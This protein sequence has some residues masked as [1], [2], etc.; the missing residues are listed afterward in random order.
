MPHLCEVYPRICL[1]TEGKA[2]K[3]PRVRVAGLQ[4]VSFAM[5]VRPPARNNSV[6]AGRISVKFGLQARR[7]GV[8]FLADARF[9]SFSKPPNRILGIP[10]L[11]FKGYREFL[12][13][14]YSYRRMSR[15]LISIE[16]EVTNEGSCTSTLTCPPVV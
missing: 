15:T 1:T 16:S 11:L 4:S 5:S 9:F 10:S 7:Y 8:R 12:P 3:N 2:R 14:G 13:R 6:P